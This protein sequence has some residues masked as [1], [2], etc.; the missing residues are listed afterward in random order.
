MLLLASIGLL[1]TTDKSYI[2]FV[3]SVFIILYSLG[4][5]LDAARH[6]WDYLLKICSIF[7]AWQGY[8]R[9]EIDLGHVKRN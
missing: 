3:A 8:V 6:I 7:E 9:M 5:D 2:W 1:V 4:K